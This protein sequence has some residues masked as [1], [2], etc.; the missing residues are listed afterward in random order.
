MRGNDCVYTPADPPKRRGL[1]DA[2]SWA[3]NLGAPLY[4]SAAG[5]GRL[6]LLQVLD[7]WIAMLKPKQLYEQPNSP[8]TVNHKDTASAEDLDAKIKQS[9][10]Q[11]C[12]FLFRRSSL[13]AAQRY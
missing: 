3:W 7:I 12:P 13:A 10:I 8:A 9:A 4:L 5:D 11:A 6:P 1:Q 2:L